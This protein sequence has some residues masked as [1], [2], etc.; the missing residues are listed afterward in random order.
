[1]SGQFALIW[2]KVTGRIWFRSGLFGLVGVATVALAAS[3]G[4]V[5]PEGWSERIGSGSVRDLLEIMASS[6]LLVATFSLGTMVAAFTAAA[7]IATPRA[8]TILIDDP[9]AQNVLATFVGAFVFSIIGLVALSAGIFA[10]DGRTV[11]LVVTVAVILLVIATLFGWLDYLAN[12]VRLGEVLNKLEARA[13]ETML[14]RAKSPYL[15]GLP[16]V[17]LPAGAHPVH[18]DETGY[19][20]SIDMP[21]LERIA[22]TAGGTIHVEIT[23]GQLVDPSRA[24]ARSSWRPSDAERAAIRKAWVVAR[25]RSF[26]QDPRYCLIVLSEVASRALSP[27]VNDP[28]TA[29]AIIGRLQ[30]LLAIW[31]AERRRAPGGEDWPLSRRVHV[32]PLVAA[33]LFEDSFGPLARDAAPMVEVGIRLQ[34]SLNALSRM[35]E[36][37]YAQAAKL[38]SGRAL[39]QAREALVLAS[40]VERLALASQG[41]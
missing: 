32:R 4:P 8:S 31:A 13:V 28:G 34:K 35:C 7:T 11:L 30:R 22:E 27:G 5:F 3:V 16:F 2:R 26:D 23:P 24:L 15:G 33:E 19:A 36:D 1:M 10:E 38:Q 41:R 40:D 17:E 12:L 39:D 14:A 18:Q 9:V 37:D 20:A 21:A 29:I 6:M 25:E